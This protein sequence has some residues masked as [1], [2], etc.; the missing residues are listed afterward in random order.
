MYASKRHT[1]AQ[2]GRRARSVKND[3]DHLI[4]KIEQKNNQINDLMS[5][6]K[7]DKSEMDQSSIAADLEARS[8]HQTIEKLKE[9]GTQYKTFN[10]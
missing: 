8:K 10:E 2:R 3:Y 4:Q 1:R 7:L 5:S 9:Q 6:Q